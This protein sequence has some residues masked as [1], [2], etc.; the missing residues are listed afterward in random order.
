MH[1]TAYFFLYVGWEEIGGRVEGGGSSYS[2]CNKLTVFFKS[3]EE[4]IR[5]VRRSCKTVSVLS[6]FRRCMDV[7][8]SGNNYVLQAVVVGLTVHVS[9][10]C[11]GGA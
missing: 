8:L 2:S 6:F 3:D 4:T 10:A 1:C 11:L 9:V 5:S 7:Q